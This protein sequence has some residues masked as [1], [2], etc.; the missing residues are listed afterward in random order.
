MSTP[1]GSLIVRL[2]GPPDA[3]SIGE[4]SVVA[5]RAAYAAVM[6]H[7]YLASLDANERAARW[8]DGLTSPPPRS[9]VMVGEH[10]SRPVGF[11][12]IGSCEGSDRT[13]EVNAL[14]LR[15]DCWRHGFGSVLLKRGEEAMRAH[16]F[17]EAVLWV[18]PGNERARRFYEARGWRHDEM[19]RDEVV[20]DITVRETRYRREL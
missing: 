10:D 13:G 19:E 9:A 5:W 18:L 11:V 4:I 12:A 2:A 16:G 3:T 6:P 17:T 20:H 1:V 7:E 15:P 8:V 14:N